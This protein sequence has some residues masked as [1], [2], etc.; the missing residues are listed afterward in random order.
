MITFF[1]YHPKGCDEKYHLR[2]AFKLMLLTIIKTA[3]FFIAQVIYSLY[4]SI[5]N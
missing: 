3:Q 5:L 4:K 2:Y 1:L